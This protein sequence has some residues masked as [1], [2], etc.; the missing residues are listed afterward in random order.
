MIEKD[1]QDE[2][3]IGLCPCKL[4][5]CS[6][7]AL[8]PYPH[9]AQCLRAFWRSRWDSNPRALADKRFS[10]PPRYD[11]FDTAPGICYSIV[12]HTRTKV[13][14]T[15]WGHITNFRA[16]MK[17]TKCLFYWVCIEI[18]NEGQPDFKTASL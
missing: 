10:R 11:H 4:M 18:L 3:P 7:F 16:V 5:L 6:V 14:G 8:L 15:H 12:N 17:S 9:K 13:L 1:R 2:N